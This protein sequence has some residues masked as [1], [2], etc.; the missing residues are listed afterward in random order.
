MKMIRKGR[1]NE[2]EEGD[3]VSGVKFIETDNLHEDAAV[4]VAA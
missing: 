2:I 3:S 4:T 1:V